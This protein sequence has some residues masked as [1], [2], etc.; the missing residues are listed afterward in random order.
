MA[1][2]AAHRTAAPPNRRRW[3]ARLPPA[4]TWARSSAAGRRSSLRVIE[5]GRLALVLHHVDD[6]TVAAQLQAAQCAGTGKHGVAA[7]LAEHVVDHLLRAE[8]LGAAQA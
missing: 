7:E 3:R 4:A 2:P 8:G 5:D 1:R 6:A